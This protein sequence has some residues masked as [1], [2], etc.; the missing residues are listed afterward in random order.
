MN[1]FKENLKKIDDDYYS[2][3][4]FNFDENSIFIKKYTKEI[5]SRNSTIKY[6][7]IIQKIIQE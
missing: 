2:V 3:S 4:D 7:E 1:L 6:E 5:M